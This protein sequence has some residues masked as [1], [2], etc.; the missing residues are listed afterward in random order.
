VLAQWQEDGQLLT[1]KSDL[2][3]VGGVKWNDEGFSSHW[4]VQHLIGIVWAATE[5]VLGGV[6]GPS[7]IATLGFTALGPAPIDDRFCDSD[8]LHR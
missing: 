8:L 3:L 6:H 5:A 2:L 4:L 7:K 1:V